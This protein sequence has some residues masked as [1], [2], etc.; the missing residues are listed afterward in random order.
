TFTRVPKE[1][2]TTVQV[3]T[4]GFGFARGGPAV[5]TVI[6]PVS[7]KR[8]AEAREEYLKTLKQ[9]E[10]RMGG[11]TPMVEAL[12]HTAEFLAQQCNTKQFNK[13]LVIFLS[14]GEPDNGRDTILVLCEAIKNAGA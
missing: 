1:I 10:D 8:F 4:I 9:A 2:E 6:S 3:A 5:Q 14:D 7:L 13:V 12:E 11:S